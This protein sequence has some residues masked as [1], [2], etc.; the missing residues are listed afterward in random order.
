[1]EEATYLTAV[2]KQRKKRGLRHHYS[3]KNFFL[4]I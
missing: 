3:F 2:K 1:M 4:M